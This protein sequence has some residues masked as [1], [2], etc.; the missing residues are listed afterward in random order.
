MT[1]QMQCNISNTGQASLNFLIRLR[2]AKWLHC[3]SILVKWCKTAIHGI[4]DDKLGSFLGRSCYMF[5]TRPPTTSCTTSNHN[6]LS[7]PVWNCEKPKC[8][9]LSRNCALSPLFEEIVPSVEGKWCSFWSKASPPRIVCCELLNVW[10]FCA[11]CAN[12]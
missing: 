4:V 10:Y 12:C 11:E 6:V 3:C 5:H 1:L 7:A 8:L 9:L 2:F